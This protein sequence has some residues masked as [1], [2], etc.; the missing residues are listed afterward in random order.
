M[1]NVIRIFGRHGEHMINLTKVSTVEY[2]HNKKRITFNF[3]GTQTS[4][5]L[6]DTDEDGT[7]EYKSIVQSLSDYH[8]EKSTK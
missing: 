8:N 1:F 4:S 3:N 7:K 6:F 2:N 5:F